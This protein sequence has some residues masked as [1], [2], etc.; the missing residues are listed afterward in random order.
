MTQRS[1]QRP[2]SGPTQQSSNCGDSDCC[3]LTAVTFPRNCPWLQEIASLKVTPLPEGS[4]EPMISW[5]GDIWTHAPLPQFG[6][7]LKNH[8]GPTAPWTSPAE[9]SVAAALWV[10]FSGPILPSSLSHE[11]I[12]HNH[13]PIHLHTK[14]SQGLLQGTQLEILPLS[15]LFL[16]RSQFNWETPYF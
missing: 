4:L 12:F 6:T 9:A 13:S 1:T 8:P 2:S 7:T 11:G 5:R 3:W 14:L 15:T 16:K 10:S